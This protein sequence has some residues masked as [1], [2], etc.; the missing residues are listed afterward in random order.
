MVTVHFRLSEIGQIEL[1]LEAAA[2]WS[3]VVQRCAV[4]DQIDVDGILAVRAGKVLGGEDI[5]N[6][7]DV[8]DVFPA[9]SGG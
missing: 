3:S 1:E 2:P 5:V 9:I 7:D 6:N 8:I 4:A